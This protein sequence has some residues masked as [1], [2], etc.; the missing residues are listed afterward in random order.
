MAK[1]SRRKLAQYVADQI[2][3]QSKIDLKKVLQQLAA[4]LIIDKRTHEAELIVRDIELS[5]Q[6]KGIVVADVYTA[7]S[8]T[9]EVTSQI[10]QMINADHLYARYHVDPTL[11]GGIKLSIPDGQLDASIQGR[12]AS[13]QSLK[14]INNH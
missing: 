3:G 14:V 5:L 11:R 2:G 12:L 4:L 1:L 13:L 10:E 7:T 8:I 9:D 6:K